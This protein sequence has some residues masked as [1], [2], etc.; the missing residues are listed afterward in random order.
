M[1]ICHNDEQLNW[2]KK[3]NK[4]KALVQK[5]SAVASAAAPDNSAL[6]TLSQPN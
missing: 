1:L 3:I 4:F 6:L 5:Y 2:N